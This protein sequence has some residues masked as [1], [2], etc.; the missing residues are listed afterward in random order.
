M[1]VLQCTLPLFTANSVVIVTFLLRTETNG[2][3][4]KLKMKCPKSHHHHPSI[5]SQSSWFAD[6]FHFGF[7]STG[8]ASDQRSYG[9]V[10]IYVCM[11]SITIRIARAPRG[12]KWKWKTFRLFIVFVWCFSLSTHFFYISVR[13]KNECVWPFPHFASVHHQ[14]S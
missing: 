6:V 7:V 13:K 9:C 5:S 1:S 14:S 11:L 4:I 10:C 3:D 8:K 12:M 2:N